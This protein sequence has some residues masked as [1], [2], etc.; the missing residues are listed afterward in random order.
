MK[1]KDLVWLILL[2]FISLFI[3]LP[4]TNPL[5]VQLTTQHPYIMGFIKTMLLATMGEVLVRRIKTGSYFKDL[6]LILKAFVWGF[7]GMVFVFVFP[8]FDGGIRSIFND[9]ILFE[10]DFMNR[11][12]YAL[13][14]S[15]SM[16]VLF[17][18]TFMMLHRITDTYINLSEG[19]IKK[20]ARVPFDDVIRSI[21][22]K[23][24]FSFVIIKTIPFF[25]IPAHTITFMLP[26]VY[27]VLMASYLSIALGVLLSIKKK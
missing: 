4:F 6:G 2:I 18:P 19:K 15:T 22:F 13:M 12:I 16:N 21:D 1:L 20:L 24:F 8:L 23:F 14:V 26:P 27:R 17:A 25:W 5:F 3:F 10:N 9:Q 11:L 7:L